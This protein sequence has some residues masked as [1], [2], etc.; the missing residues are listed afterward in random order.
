MIALP[1]AQLQAV[2]LTRRLPL[3]FATWGAVFRLYERPWFLRIWVKQEIAKSVGRQIVLHC[4]STSIP[5]ITLEYVA[6]A[7]IHGQTDLDVEV[8][9]HT[10]QAGL[11]ATNSYLLP[12]GLRAVGS[13][14]K[15]RETNLQY[16]TA[17]IYT[18]M[19]AFRG[20]QASDAKDMVFALVGM[21]QTDDDP[22]LIPDYRKSVEEVFLSAMFLM[23]KLYGLDVLYEAGYRQR[24]IH[25]VPSW[26]ADWTFLPR[27]VS[28]FAPPRP[29]H[30]RATGSTGPVLRS[31]QYSNP[32]IL[33][34]IL[35][36]RVTALTPP[37]Q[38]KDISDDV[39]EGI[40]NGLADYYFSAL[41]L[42]GSLQTSGP[43]TLTPSLEESFWRT[44]TANRTHDGLPAPSTYAA[45][46][47]SVHDYLALW[48]TSG[49]N[50]ET[51]TADPRAKDL[52][53]AYQASWFFSSFYKSA[54][55]RSFC[56]TER[57]RMA[58]VPADT[59]LG[60]RVVLLLGKDL[61]V[62]LRAAAYEGNEAA[63]R[64]IGDCY[65]DGLNDGEGLRDGDAPAEI[66][67]VLIH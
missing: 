44:L 53:A 32:L 42:A 13:I 1:F 10:L 7:L 14:G 34:G 46:N 52:H 16:A 37:L 31:P 20:Y 21:V 29:S 48:N 30:Y 45:E 41:R 40:L 43:D 22:V 47:K 15:F 19:T 3:E 8:F 57:G 63:Y 62:V 38:V 39:N 6:Y 28:F 26:V 58:L 4:G 2:L 24:S 35:A 54:F 61:P 25:S 18:V 65:V 5:W 55:H 49:R 59:E 9:D 56:V 23:L 12:R 36:D 60:D 51:L 64:F 66:V 11:K 50:T 67:P 33:D 17:N 27:T